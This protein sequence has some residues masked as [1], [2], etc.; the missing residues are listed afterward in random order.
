MKYLLV[1][2]LFCASVCCGNMKI[3]FVA[4]ISYLQANSA[5]L[6]GI[7]NISKELSVSR[8]E[9]IEVAF[10]EFD[11]S[12]KQSDMLS[13]LYMNGFSGAVLLPVDNN[14][15]LSSKIS[16]LK[17]SHFPIVVLD[18]KVNFSDALCSIY[19]NQDMRIALI[20]NVINKRSSK[21]TKIA[22]YLKGT[23]S[24]SVPV[25]DDIQIKQYLPYPS[26]FYLF[27]SIFKSRILSID[28]VDFYS[29]YADINKVEIMRRD[30]YGEVFFSPKILSN[31][32][33]I[34]PDTDRAFALCVGALPM[35]EFY[36]AT[37][38]ITDCI[39]DDYYGWGVFAIRAIVDY[40]N[41][42]KVSSQYAVRPIYVTND[43]YKIFSSDWQ[44][45]LR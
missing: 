8:G 34:T 23:S 18:N 29:S 20:E 41:N 4:D 33:P 13:N 17:K 31:M 21:N 7:K 10:F 16:E 24:K 39:Y 6:N 5:I 30:S 25:N 26:D 40:K 38:A 22:C 44:K 2:V 36:L 12:K 45:W 14:A 1:V 3:A 9:Q 43:N 11:N 27:T 28:V 19:T 42:V 35:L 15:E 37:S 32:Q